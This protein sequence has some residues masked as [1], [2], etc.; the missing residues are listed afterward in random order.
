MGGSSRGKGLEVRNGEKSGL[1]RA[2]ECEGRVSG[3][4]G[5]E[6]RVVRIRR[7]ERLD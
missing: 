3:E 6:R 1:V 7:G 2:S 5:V 4:G